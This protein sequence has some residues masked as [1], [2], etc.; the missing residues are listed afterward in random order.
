MGYKTVSLLV[1]FDGIV[2]DRLMST[3]SLLIS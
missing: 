1:V 3:G 2:G